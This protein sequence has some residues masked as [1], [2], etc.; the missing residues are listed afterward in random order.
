MQSALKFLCFAVVL[1]SAL[2]SVQ[3]GRIE[4]AVSDDIAV[5]SA[6]LEDGKEPS[7]EQLRRMWHYNK[8]RMQV[9]RPQLPVPQ[10]YVPAAIAEAPFA[11]AVY[12]EAPTFAYGTWKPAQPRPRTMYPAKAPVYGRLV[13]SPEEFIYQ[14]PPMHRGYE[15]SFAQVARMV[16]ASGPIYAAH[17]APPPR[18]QTYF[19]LEYPV[20][21]PILPVRVSHAGRFHELQNALR[22]ERAREIQTQQQQQRANNNNGNN[23]HEIDEESAAA[24]AAGIPFEQY[25]RSQS[26][27]QGR[28]YPPSSLQHQRKD[29]ISAKMPPAAVV[30]SPATSGAETEAGNRQNS[31]R[32]QYA[33]RKPIIRENQQQS[34]PTEE[35]ATDDPQS[36]QLAG[37]QPAIPKGWVLGEW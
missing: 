11:A 6:G 31:Y 23:N 36:A 20:R 8:R 9:V 28:K 30:G 27:D 16:G 4:G 34:S 5:P 22:L 19:R 1:L 14:K 2:L 32:Q 3:T 24:A 13:H 26:D 10:Q 37:L 33:E 18:P 7:C 25:G 35:S 15:G 12:S 21:R 29:D 17:I